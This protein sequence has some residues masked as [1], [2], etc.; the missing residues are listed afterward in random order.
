[1]H[2]RLVPT[3]L[4]I[5]M[6]ACTGSKFRQ[7]ASAPVDTSS[8]RPNLYADLAF[9]A[10][11]YAADIKGAED[12]DTD[13]GYFRFRTEYVGDAAFGGGFSLE[14]AASDDDLFEEVGSL[15]AQAATSDLFL[16]FI[17][18]PTES[19][20]FRLPVRVGPYFHNVNFDEDSN[21]SEI[22]WSGFGFRAEVEPEYWIF[23]EPAFSFGLIGDLSLGA[24]LTSIDATILGASDDFDGNGYTFGAGLGVQALF[25]NHILTK[26]GYVYRATT[27]DESDD[28]GFISIREND[29]SFSGIAFQVGVRF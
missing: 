27:E 23:Q 21:L 9:G 14:G 4:L 13:G 29:T 11:T 6:S 18:V 5:A 26:L 12:G 10:G 17:G 7:D 8:T 15:D 1:M 20:N 16:Y 24:H 19:H 25:S 3:I 22:D 2:S 28:N